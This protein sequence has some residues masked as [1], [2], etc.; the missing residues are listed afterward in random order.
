MHESNS[1][2][3]VELQARSQDFTLRARED[4]RVFL[5]VAHI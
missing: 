4:A 5:V 3:Y 2:K 1:A